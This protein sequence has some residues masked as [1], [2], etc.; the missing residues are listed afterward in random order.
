MRRADE[1]VVS[2]A[3]ERA[4]GAMASTA[5]S[6]T[7]GSFSLPDTARR[8]A[9]LGLRRDRT[10]SL[11]GDGD[12]VQA[13]LI[14]E[15]TSP[16]VNLTWMLDAW[17]FLP[18]EAYRTG[19]QAAAALAAEAVARAPTEVP[20]TDK[21]LVVPDGIST[22]PLLDAGFEKLADLHFYV[23]NRSGFRRYHE[24]IADRYGELGVKMI[25]RSAARVA[26]S[27]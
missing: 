5:L 25:K 7:P 27:A 23:I 15:N 6:L 12:V 22:A 18:V 8:F 4:F 26:R 9:R 21:L 10:V 14:K 17:W 11:I 3:A 1:I 13:A 20:E 16:G 19:D 2:R 24:Y